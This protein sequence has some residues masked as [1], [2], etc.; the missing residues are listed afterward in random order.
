MPPQPTLADQHIDS[1]LTDLS[2]GYDQP[3]SYFV[4]DQV[5]PVVGS[6]KK[7]DKIATFT[8]A[9]LRRDEM[10]LRAP[11]AES[12]GGGYSV[13]RDSY[14]CEV[15]AS[16]IDVDD[17]TVAGSDNP[18]A[19]MED[20]TRVLVEREK[21]KREVRFAAEWFASSLWTGGTSNDPTAASL[22]A[23]WDD[24]ASTP[25]EDLAEQGH[26][27]LLEFGREPNTLVLNNLGWLSL[28]NHPDVVDRIKYTSSEPVS[29]Q[30]VAR[31]LGLDRV[32][33]SKATR[34]TA[35]EG[36]TETGAS[37]LGNSAL[38]V[39]AAPNPGR[40]VPSGGY[41]FVWTG[42][43][44]SRDGRRMRSFYLDKEASWRIEIE[45]AFDLKMVDANAGVFITS[46]AS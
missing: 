41:T 16:H 45:S 22:S 9:D 46:V 34:N 27:I 3:T 6:P 29:E 2:V 15:W 37:I 35:A 8:R 39:Y 24:P 4:A 36:L 40:F 13:S 20:A 31:L 21:I 42:Y 33:V 23:A 7:S 38:L 26:N 44:G 28:K 30:L 11:G 10:Q 5:F 14:A 17:Q 19:P 32:L 18:Y 25:I 1:Y 43:P 12:A